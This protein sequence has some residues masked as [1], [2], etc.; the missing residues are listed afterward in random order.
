MNPDAA[1]R[2]VSNAMPSGR[3]VAL[4]EP[5]TLSEVRALFEEYEAALMHN[6]VD[7]LDRLFWSSTSTVRFGIAENLYG[8]E[9]IAAF[10]RTVTSGA[11]DR[12]LS[13]T[14]VTTLGD[15]AASVCT[16]FHQHGRSGRQSQVWFH[17]PE[18]W[19]IVSAH[20]SFSEE[21]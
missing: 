12:T 5:S 3:P 13:N 6:D 2:T 10:R 16:E 21:S 18:G 17:M 1:R 19:R 8:A 20:V 15:H 4:N 14:V 7:T 9:A 11:V